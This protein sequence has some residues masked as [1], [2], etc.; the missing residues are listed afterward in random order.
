MTRTSFEAITEQKASRFSEIDTIVNTLT[1]QMMIDSVS[2][3]SELS[4]KAT[5]TERETM[6][7]F[8]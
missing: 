6:F 7:F 3:Y 1:I 5:K 8:F 4:R 2:V